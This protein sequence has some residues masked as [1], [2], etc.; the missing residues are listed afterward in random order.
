[1]SSSVTSNEAIT[2]S[3][4]P[5]LNVGEARGVPEH[6]ARIPSEALTEAQAHEA[7]LHWDHIHEVA[8]RRYAL[9]E[10]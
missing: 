6:A 5:R 9:R 7:W 10:A 1:M 4:G 3:S 8:D 2:H